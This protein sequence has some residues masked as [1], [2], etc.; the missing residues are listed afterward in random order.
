VN[1]AIETN[2]DFMNVP[3]P[4][5]VEVKREGLTSCSGIVAVL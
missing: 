4:Y 1:S 3:H 5:F 2:S